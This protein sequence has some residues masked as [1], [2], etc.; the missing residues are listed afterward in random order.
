MSVYPARDDDDDEE[1][2]YVCTL[3]FEPGEPVILYVD[4]DDVWWLLHLRCLP[5]MVEL[6]PEDEDGARAERLGGVAARGS[7]R[8]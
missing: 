3:G 2:C 8:R 1:L 7:K 4:D 6:A 5:R